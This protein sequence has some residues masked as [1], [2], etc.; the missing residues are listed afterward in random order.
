MIDN[1]RCVRYYVLDGLLHIV[2]RILAEIGD[3]CRGHAI[4]S[5][6]YIIAYIK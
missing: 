5:L 4:A 1:L 2:E 3:V 6:M